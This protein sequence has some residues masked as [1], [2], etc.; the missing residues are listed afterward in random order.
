MPIPS[1]PTAATAK[2]AKPITPTMTTQTPAT[3]RHG[4][5]DERVERGL[6]AGERYARQT[7]FAA[8]AQQGQERL[9]RGARADRR[10]RRAGQRAGEQPGARGRRA[11]CASL[12]ATSWRATTCSGRCSTTRM[13]CAGGMPKAVAAARALRRINSLVTIEPHVTDVTAENIEALLEGVDVVLDGTDNFETRYLLNDACVKAG[14]PWI[15]SGVIAA[16][17]V[18][19]TVLPGETACLRC[20]FPERP[21]PGTTPTCD[22]GGRA[23]RHRRRDHG[24]GVHRGAQ[25]AGGQRRLVRGLTWV[26]LWENTFERVELPR[27]ADCPTCGL[28]DYEYLDAPLDESG[29]SLCGR[30]AVQVRPPLDGERRRSTWPRWRSGWRR[31]ARWPATIFCCACAWTATR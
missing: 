18:T 8:S 9:E 20:V 25:A 5:H 2:T 28:G 13:T 11:I 7:L 14:M 30:N 23:Q 4:A 6:G 21:L 17:G 29:V 1:D 26:D 31:L 16:Y 12:T 15:Y 10:L 22:T 19:L 24:H 3:T 27:T